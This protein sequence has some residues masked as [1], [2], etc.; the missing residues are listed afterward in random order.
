MWRVQLTVRDCQTGDALRMFPAIFTFS[1]GGTVTY[2]TAG[3]LPSLS[4]PGL[5]AWHHVDGHNYS[6]VTEVFIFSPAGA[7][8]QTHRLTRVIEVSGDGNEFT[9]TVALEILGTNGNLIA[10]GCATTAASRME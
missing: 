10:T 3:Q 4:T 2:S 8:I 5:G 1:K 6:A 7:W 9:D